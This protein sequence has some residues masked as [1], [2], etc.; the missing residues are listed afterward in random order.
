[1]QDDKQN[2]QTTKDHGKE[3]NKAPTNFYFHQK[4][5]SF[6]LSLSR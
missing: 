3:E 4:T 2:V 1:M 5:S 6:A